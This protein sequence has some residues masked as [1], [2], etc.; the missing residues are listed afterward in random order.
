MDLSTMDFF[1]IVAVVLVTTLSQV[2]N[3]NGGSPV[4]VAQSRHFAYFSG[5]EAYSYL[6]SS[7]RSAKF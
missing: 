2:I 6:L 5:T 3:S 4:G 1:I 7:I